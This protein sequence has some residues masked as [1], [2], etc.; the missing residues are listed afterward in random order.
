MGFNDWATEKIMATTGRGGLFA[1]FLS[2]EFGV[3]G[4]IKERTGVGIVATIS[5][6]S[7]ATLLK[8]AA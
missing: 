3:V 4:F 2:W 8:I 5:Q 6:P 7:K 1:F